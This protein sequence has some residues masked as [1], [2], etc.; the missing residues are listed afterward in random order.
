MATVSKKIA[1]DIIAGLYEDDKPIKI[2]KYQNAF[3]GGDSYGV[4]FEDMS[5][6]TYS[7]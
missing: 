7:I 4:I 6:D 5:L 3:D 2:V 1:D